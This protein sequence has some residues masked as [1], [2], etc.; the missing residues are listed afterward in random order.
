MIAYTL[1]HLI[2]FV[3][4][5]VV[6]LTIYVFVRNEMARQVAA[7]TSSG[8][9]QHAFVSDTGSDRA[10]FSAEVGAPSS[11]RLSVGEAEP[12]FKTSGMTGPGTRRTFR[13]KVE[14][15]DRLTS[16]SNCC[17]AITAVQP[18]TDYGDGPWFLKTQGFSLAAGEPTFIPL[19]SY[20]EPHD[21]CI[22]M[23]TEN[24]T[25]HLDAKLQHII[26]LRATA[27]G[28]SWA[29]FRCR[30][31]VD[32]RHI[33]RIEPETASHDVSPSLSVVTGED[34]HYSEITSTTYPLATRV[35][36]I[37]IKNR[38]KSLHAC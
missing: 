31:W 3:L 23:E 1:A 6:V 34:G 25:P 26:T 11:L 27:I 35:V 21:T 17:I 8:A 10:S 30:L 28:T 36:R 22:D 5:I 9:S 18:R 19:A 37:G 24:G 12:Y 13:L 29:E 16:L 15:A 20:G 2:P 14:N 7:A 32:E 33:F 4:T 38:R